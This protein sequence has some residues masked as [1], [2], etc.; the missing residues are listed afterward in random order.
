MLS[1][2]NSVDLKL[3]RAKGGA[4]SF[5]ALLRLADVVVKCQSVFSEFRSRSWRC[6]CDDPAGSWGSC[7][8]VL[9]ASMKYLVGE[10]S[11]ECWDPE[12]GV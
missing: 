12:L 6:D 5:V 10:D 2:V 7:I 11:A 9:N 8:G 3:V 4:D 1:W